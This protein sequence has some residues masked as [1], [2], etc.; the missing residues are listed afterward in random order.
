MKRGIFIG[1]KGIDIPEGADLLSSPHMRNVLL[2]LLFAATASASSLTLTAQLQVNG[3]TSPAYSFTGTNTFRHSGSQTVGTASANYSDLVTW[4]YMALNVGTTSP[5]ATDTAFSQ[6][7]GTVTDIFHVLNALPGSM[8][9][10]DSEYQTTAYS[11]AAGVM[12]GQVTMNFSSTLT[13]GPNGCV[14]PNY[15]FAI[16]NGYYYGNGAPCE[17]KASVGSSGSG[18]PF[19]FSAKVALDSLAGTTSAS[20][21]DDNYI[22]TY[23]LVLDSAGN[24]EPNARVYADSGFPYHTYPFLPEPSSLPLAGGGLL[25]L[26]ALYFARR[27]R[28]SAER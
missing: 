28:A 6:T 17:E 3:V 11:V 4:D 18:I 10:V 12:P 7:T 23:V 26:G 16:P 13:G 20:L 1:L 2:V 9:E 19:T 27:K 25:I 8:L 14:L 22:S 15:D 24:W 5:G 21:I